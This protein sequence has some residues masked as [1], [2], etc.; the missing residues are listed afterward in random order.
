MRILFFVSIIFFAFTINHTNAQVTDVFGNNVPAMSGSKSKG[1]SKDHN[2][3]DEQGRKQGYWERRYS[4]GKPA[5][6]VTFKDDKPVGKMTRY[7]F[8]GNKKVIVNYDENQYGDAQLFDEKGKLTAKGFYNGTVKDSLWQF[9]SPEGAL[10][11][12]EFYREGKKNGI[13]THYYKKGNIAEEIEWKEDVRDGV[14]RKYHENGQ[15]KMTSGY[16]EGK[17]EGPYVVYFEDG[18]IEVQ[19]QF[20]NGL[21]EGTWIVFTTLETVAYKIEYKEGKT[22]NTEFFDE[23]QRKLFEEFQKNKGNLK[24]P[25]EFKHDPDQYM[26]G[27]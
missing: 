6:Q 18:K 2:K 10:Y 24:D 17:I 27:M 26:R 8:N 22:L 13:T 21:E 11:T 25:E 4:N 1:V 5:Y 14:W 15:L 9:F 12:K 19:G 23:K 3:K 7:Y 16:K 20:K